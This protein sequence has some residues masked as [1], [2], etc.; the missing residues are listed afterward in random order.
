MQ[1]ADPRPFRSIAQVLIRRIWA[2]ALVILFLALGFQAWWAQIQ[3][4]QHFTELI[5]EVADTNVPMMSLALWDIEPQALRAQLDIMAKRPEIGFVQLKAATGQVF[6][7]G[8]PHLLDSQSVYRLNISSPQG[9]VQL[10]ELILSINPGYF[11]R[12]FLTM[13]WQAAI[14]SCVLTVLI[15]WLIVVMLQRDLER[16]LQNIAQYASELTSDNLTE[17]LQLNRRPNARKDEIDLFAMAFT[18]LQQNLRQRIDDLNQLVEE[19]T[20]QQEKLL[21]ANQKS[22]VANL[23]K[24]Q[25]LATISHELKTPLNGILGMAQLLKHADT[26][27]I[28]RAEFAQII[29]DSGKSLQTL[30]NDLLDIS[31]IEA[32]KLVLRSEPCDIVALTHDVTTLFLQS[33]QLKNLDIQSKW[34]GETG[35]LYRTD[36]IRLRQMLSNLVSNAIKFTEKGFVHIEGKEIE[37]NG[38]EAILE[39]SVTDSGI[40]I[41]QDKLS[42]LFKRFSQ[43][44]SSHS[45]SF[46]GTGLG[47]S[48]IEGLAKRMGGQVGVESQADIGSR[49][50]FRIQVVVLDAAGNSWQATP[51]SGQ[52][53]AAS[54]HQAPVVEGLS[55]VKKDYRGLVMVVEDNPINQ[56]IVE[57]VLSRIGIS[58]VCFT[59]GQEAVNA[60]IQGTQPQ[61]VLMDMQMP[62]M[63]GLEATRAI[64]AWEC[65]VHAKPIPIIGL[66]AGSG[67]DLEKECLDSGMSAVLFKPV[68]LDLLQT[69]VLP[70]IQMTEHV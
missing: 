46:E 13:A 38:A 20:F 31:Q 56:K 62:V 59:N 29:L 12:N 28:Q 18:K 5:Q 50:W 51:P 19:R 11:W 65:S 25:F 1:L 66:T 48:I 44:D 47:L 21:L 24:S 54:P 23:A 3:N 22:Q 2:L 42:L 34:L 37:R 4:K 43:V 55:I 35:P 41:S 70:Y 14:G 36:P 60:V 52:L 61:V 32:N 9:N 10:G 27:E 6:E 49:F 8:D 64:R 30:I 57:S 68:D 63:N 15:C 53:Q 58:C 7:Q 67:A 26:T 16:P 40:G 39:F 69:L 17:S 45:R 33:A